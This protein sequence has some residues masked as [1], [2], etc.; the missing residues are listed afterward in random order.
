LVAIFFSTYLH[1]ECKI[2]DNRIG[3]QKNFQSVALNGQII[4]L[5]QVVNDYCKQAD[6]L[7]YKA[8]RTY[9]IIWVF[10]QYQV[11]DQR[12]RS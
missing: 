10:G 2:I 8:E 7:V 11:L 6:N 9:Y 1:T 5:S 3:D 12:Q 4:I